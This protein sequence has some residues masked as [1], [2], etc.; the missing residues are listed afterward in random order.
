M[1]PGL[2]EPQGA[3]DFYNDVSSFSSD[4][5]IVVIAL[6]GLIARRFCGART[7]FGR[8]SRAH[9]LVRSARLANGRAVLTIALIKQSCLVIHSWRQK[10]SVVF[11]R[12]H[13]RSLRFRPKNDRSLPATMSPQLDPILLNRMTARTTRRVSFISP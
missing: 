11:T 10:R 5:I 2:R 3:R 1:P 12:L 13:W 6:R 7:R 9:R 4:Y 8:G